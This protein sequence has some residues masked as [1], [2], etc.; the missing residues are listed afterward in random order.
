M[1][2]ACTLGVLLVGV[3]DYATGVEARVFPLYYVPIAI[4]SLRVA[5]SVGIGLAVLINQHDALG[6]G[7]VVR[8]IF[9]EP[10]SLPLQ[11]CHAGALVQ[12]RCDP[13]CRHREAIRGRERAQPA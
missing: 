2:I 11:L 7:D 13:G 1:T 5:G 4:A 9:L 10:G 8:W 12:R 6:T 3:I